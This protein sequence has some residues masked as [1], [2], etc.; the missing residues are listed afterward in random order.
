VNE[1]LESGLR[2]CVMAGITADEGKQ[3][4]PVTLPANFD[5]LQI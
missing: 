2:Y 3:A 5:D 1:W 4:C